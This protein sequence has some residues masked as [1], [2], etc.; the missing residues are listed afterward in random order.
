M[1]DRKNFFE[2]ITVFIWQ[3]SK[4]GGVGNERGNQPITRF[5]GCERR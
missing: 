4:C 5:R 1:S 2:K 3:F